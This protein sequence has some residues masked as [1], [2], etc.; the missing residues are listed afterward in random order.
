MFRLAKKHLINIICIMI[1]NLSKKNLFIT[2]LLCLNISILFL[3][4]CIH[5]INVDEREHLYASYM[6]HNGYLPY[7][8]FFEHHHPLLWYVFA[9]F[10]Y[11]FDNTPYIWYV[12]RT[13]SLIILLGCAG[14]V[15]KITHLITNNRFPACLAVLFYTSFQIVQNA[16]TEFRPDNL[17]ILFFLSGLYYYFKYDKEKN[18][19]Y[20]AISYTLLFLSFMTL[21]KNIFLLLTL[22]I[23]IIY[24]AIKKQEQRRQILST[25]LIPIDLAILYVVYLYFTDTLKDYFE[26]NWLIYLHHFVNYN[27]ISTY[28]YIMPVIGIICIFIR[29]TQKLPY[30]STIKILYLVETIIL[31][32]TATSSQYLLPL[33]PFLAIILAILIYQFKEKYHLATLAILLLINIYAL[34]NIYNYPFVR[35]KRF[36]Y[37]SSITLSHTAKDDLIIPDMLWIGGLRKNALGYYWFGLDG[38]ARLDYKIFHRHAFPDI[39][40]IILQHSPKLIANAP[41]RNCLDKNNQITLNCVNEQTIPEEVYDT[42]LQSDLMFLR[43]D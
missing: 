4:A 25:L 32:M 43:I 17:M 34:Y 20:L 29:N 5:I 15:Y 23:V 9:P 1:K 38:D 27:L 18:W 37:L 42:Y 2:I 30:L 39:R 11:F 22:G 7:K 21:Q 6:V 35:V 33:Y 14:F 40:S 24:T 16:G 8:D 13:F 41:I 19:A 36:V 12:I 26:L 28:A 3:Y 10:L 31:I